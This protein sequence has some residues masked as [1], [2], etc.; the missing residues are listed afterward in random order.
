MGIKIKDVAENIGGFK[1]NQR[2]KI[3]EISDTVI[4]DGTIEQAE[5]FAAV[6]GVLSYEVQESTIA[7]EY[8]NSESE[9]G[10]DELAFKI[11]D[12]DKTIKALQGVGLDEY[13]INQT[14]REVQ[15]INFSQNEQNNLKFE[16]KIANFVRALNKEG[17]QYGQATKRRIDSR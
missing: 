9:T 5:D 12:V 3:T 10:F 8:I 1:N 13:A 16:D 2:D 7:K 4:I 17:I 6:M 14:T 11:D 15:I